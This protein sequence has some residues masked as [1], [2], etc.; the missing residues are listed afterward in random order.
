MKCMDCVDLTDFFLFSL[1]VIYGFN[2]SFSCFRGI[3]M[4]LVHYFYL[5]LHAWKNKICKK[6]REI[7]EC[8]HMITLK[9][10][11]FLGFTTALC[12]E[13]DGGSTSN[14]L[15]LMLYWSEKMIRNFM[16]LPPN[17][18][19]IHKTNNRLTLI[20]VFCF[21]VD[22]PPPVTFVTSYETQE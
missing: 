9:S 5:L 14:I 12:S 17:T 15:M 16:Y 6:T 21:R 1:G 2:K 10:F 7:E 20:T 22:L 4:N 11:E 18:R 3:K 19:L 13:S 8:V